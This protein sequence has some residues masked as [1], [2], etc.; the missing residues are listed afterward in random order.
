M[1]RAFALFAGIRIFPLDIT[2]NTPLSADF[3]NALQAQGKQFAY[4]QLAYEAYSLVSGEPFYDMWDV[5]AT[6]W[7]TNPG[8]YQ[9]ASPTPL[10]IET[11]GF[12]QGWIR[13]A[14]PS[15]KTQD[16]FLSFA[17]KPAFYSYVLGLLRAP[18]AAGG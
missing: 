3:M 7:L 2:N 10:E 8:L 14:G 12:N 1:E 15:R 16:V 6:C 18:A 13:P 11:W 4:S 17:D 5:T 9:A